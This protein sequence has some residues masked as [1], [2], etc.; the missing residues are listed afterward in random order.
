MNG[1]DK[2][3]VD[4]NT[5]FVDDREEATIGMK[6]IDGFDFER[7]IQLMS[8]IEKCAT[9]GVKATSIAGIAQASLNEMNE[10]AKTIAKNRAA[11]LAKLEAA[12]ALKVAMQKQE[13]E[14]KAKAQAEKDAEAANVKARA[15]PTNPAPADPARTP[16]A[17]SRTA[18]IADNNARRV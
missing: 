18:T 4:E 1:E 16:I 5:N 3:F 12:A 2:D 14:A 13:V 7:A 9:V 15:I 8:V 17:A 6:E 11:E 10:A